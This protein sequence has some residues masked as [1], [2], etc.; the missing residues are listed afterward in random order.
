MPEKDEDGNDKLDDDGN[1]LKQKICVDPKSK[2]YCGIQ[3][4][5][6]SFVAC[7]ADQSCSAV[8]VKGEDVETESYVCTCPE[9][10]TTCGTRC[11]NPGANDT[12]GITCDE[13]STGEVC[14]AGELF[15][16][17][18]K[19]TGTD[20]KVTTSYSCECYTG[21]DKVTKIVES[22]QPISETNDEPVTPAV[23]KAV[24]INPL[25]DKD[26][27]GASHVQCG[28]GQFCANGECQCTN[29][30]YICNGKCVL[31]KDHDSCNIDE[32]CMN[33]IRCQDNESC[34]LTTDHYECLLTKCEENENLCITDESRE[35]IAKTDLNHCGKCN[36]DCAKKAGEGQI[37]KSCAEPQSDQ[38]DEYICKYE[39][40]ADSHYAQCH[41]QTACVNIYTDINNCGECGKQCTGTN[42][43]IEGE[44]KDNECEGN[45]C[46]FDNIEGTP[47]C[48]SVSVA[49]GRT[50]DNCKA[51]GQVCTEEG[52][53]AG[54]V[55][56]DQGTHPVFDENGKAYKCEENTDY[57]CAPKD[58]A[59]LVDCTIQLP[60]NGKW[61][62]CVG[63]GVCEITCNNNFELRNINDKNECICPEDYEIDEAGNCVK[64]NYVTDCVAERYPA[65]YHVAEDRRSCVPNSNDAC[66]ASTWDGEG[67]YTSYV[68]ACADPLVCKDDGT[69]KCKEDGYELNGMNLCIP[70]KCMQTTG[71]EYITSY[72]FGNGTCKIDSCGNGFTPSDRYLLEYYRSCKCNYTTCGNQCVNTKTDINNCGSCGNVCSDTYSCNDG[73]CGCTAGQLECNGKCVANDVNNCGACGNKCNSN[74]TCSNGICMLNCTD[75]KDTCNNLC[76]GT[77]KTGEYC[78]FSNSTSTRICNN[79]KCQDLID[80]KAYDYDEACNNCKGHSNKSCIRLST[81]GDSING[82]KVKS[83]KAN[84]KCN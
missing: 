60:E 58:S 32:T 75:N 51:K 41:G 22:T 23:E 67:A 15:F 34:V 3:A 31:P 44:C 14:N 10:Q 56:C 40:D 5:C 76:N 74:Q 35:C 38:D 8:K 72:R 24:C 26:Y 49:C 7:G 21:Y 55:K 30:G 17:Q 81:S 61:V 6:T 83:C 33:G 53:C 62:K 80:C 19:T 12:C 4:D 71:H 68:Q 37:V 36:N 2:E 78:K 63:D 73:K 1:V 9:G 29:G 25:S 13:K 66:A 48:V 16:C 39:C 27:C 70:S 20:D 84:N 11:V 43:C 65:N 47:I 59:S 45:Q 57:Q 82:Y 46:Q 50:C 79:N 64:I 69:C 28:E 52:I 42:I 77:S 54:E 18:T